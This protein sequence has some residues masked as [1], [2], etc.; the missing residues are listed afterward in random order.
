MRSSPEHSRD[1]VGTMP[2]EASTGGTEQ[3][4]EPTVEELKQELCEAHRREAATAE[5]TRIM[6][7]VVTEF[8]ALSTVVIVRI[9]TPLLSTIRTL[10]LPVAFTGGTN[11][12]LGGPGGAA[13]PRGRWWWAGRP[14]RATRA[15]AHPVTGAGM[16]AGW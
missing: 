1:W 8:P 12:G 15:A 14:T 5:L 10:V 13:G 7:R 4:R 3:Y 6:P 9:L 11:T 2:S 16:R